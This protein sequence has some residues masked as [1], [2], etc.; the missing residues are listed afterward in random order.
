MPL[1]SR[2]ST[3]GPRTPSGHEEGS[4]EEERWFADRLAPSV[5]RKV[6]AAMSRDVAKN[7]NPAGEWCRGAGTIETGQPIPVL[8]GDRASRRR[9]AACRGLASCGAFTGR[10]RSVLPGARRRHPDGLI[11]VN[12]EVIRPFRRCSVGLGP[13]RTW[14]GQVKGSQVQILSARYTK[15]DRHLSVPL[16]VVP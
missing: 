4:S 14:L 3:A 9:P 13:G 1:D 5:G 8:A 7:R 10:E 11:Q 16:L 2:S 6:G 15:R 12:N